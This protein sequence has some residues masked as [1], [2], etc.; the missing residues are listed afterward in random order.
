MSYLQSSIG[1]RWFIPK[2]LIKG[3]YKYQVKVEDIDSKD[4]E[5]PCSICMIDLAEQFDPNGEV[6][7]EEVVRNTTE[8]S[9]GGLSYH[10]LQSNT[11]S[12]IEEPLMEAVKQNKIAYKTPCGHYF[13]G[14]CLKTWMDMK[15]DCPMCRKPLP[16]YYE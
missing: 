12:V 6:D 14:K 8:I 16:P 11:S 15:S 7:P 1:A 5:Q 3:L 13:H 10:S 2:S 9:E 4:L